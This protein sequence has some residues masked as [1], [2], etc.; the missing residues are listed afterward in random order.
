LLI[1]TYPIYLL[2]VIF[3]QA[4]KEN[5]KHDVG[6]NVL[7]P[8]QPIIVALDL[9]KGYT[10]NKLTG[11]SIK[12]LI[13]SLGDTIITGVPYSI[14]GSVELQLRKPEIIRSKM[15]SKE[16]IGSNVN[17]IR[18][19]PKII[20]AD[21]T[22]SFYTNSENQIRPIQNSSGIVVTGKSIPAIG[23]KIPL[24]QPQPIRVQPMRFKDNAIA[25]IQYLDI[26]QGLSYSYITAL[27]EDKNGYLWF[28]TDGYGLCKYDGVYLT[29]YT[30]KEGLLNNKVTC[31]NED[32]QGRIWIGNSSGISVLDGKS[33]IQFTEKDGIPGHTGF[34]K[35][36]RKGNLWFGSEIGG[37]TM[38]D[39]NNFITYSAKEGLP[40]NSISDFFEDSKG[41]KWI[42]T[43]SGMIK[44]DGK[45]FS[46]FN[47]HLNIL[48]A[49]YSIV[50]DRKGNIWFG[51]SYYGLIKYDGKVFTNYTENNGLPDHSIISMMIDRNDDV[52]ICTRYSGITKFDGTNFTAYQ[53]E[54]GLSENKTLDAIE[55]SQGNIWV[56]TFGGGINKINQNGFSEKVRLENVGNSR[57][58]PIIKDTM[59]QLWFGTEGGGLFA[60]DGTNII[61]Y[62]GK[63]PFQVK[64]FRSALVD[65][66]NNLWFGETDGNGLYKYDYKQFLYYMPPRSSANYAL[67]EDRNR[68]IWIGTSEEGAV[69]FNGTDF[70]YYNI[71][72]G[73]SSNRVL[74]ITEDKKNN[75]WFGT[76][77]AGV[78]KFDGQLFTV[79]SEKQGLFCKSVSSIIEDKNGNLWFGTLEAGLCKFDGNSFTYYTEKQGLALNA[80]WSV[81]EDFEGQIWAGTDKGLSLLIPQ[82]DT[83]TS[84]KSYVIYS[85][86]LGDGLNAT[87]FNLNGVCI[88]NSNRIWWATGKALITRDLSVPFKTFIPRSLALTHIEINGKLFDFRSL[89]D[90]IKD[91]INF[92]SIAPFHNYPEHLSIAYDQ[93]HI[94]FHFSAIDW[95]ASH[96]IKYSYRLIGSDHEWSFP[97]AEASADY[98][99]LGYGNYEFQVKAIGESQVWTDPVS[100]KFKI[101][102]AWWQT[103]LFKITAAII[104]VL[105]IMYVLWLIYLYRLRKQKILL[106]KKLAVEYERQRISAD[107]HDDIGSTLSSINIYAGLAKKQGDNQFYLDS[108]SQNIND[109]V[110]KLDDLVWSIK[111]GHD[112]LGNI[113][114]RLKAYAEPITRSKQ[115]AFSISMNDDWK[116]IKP[117][118]G[119]KHHLFMTAKELIN[120]A[121][122]H[123]DCKNIHIEFK[124]INNTLYVIVKDDGKGFNENAIRKDRNGLKN[125]AQR[126]TEMEG[127]L[128]IRSSLKDGTIVNIEIPI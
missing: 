38:Y 88:D 36:D 8:S 37:I 75:L 121:V 30:Q 14:Q 125:I 7:L 65:H 84:K 33:F 119:I 102:P 70:V 73:F 44:F 67:F 113:V 109:V 92:S 104:S 39:G 111:A 98:R 5:N 43:I 29:T 116:D 32:K 55:D 22:V 56:G 57:V 51:S 24:N 62:I 100:Y 9:D 11:D 105:V 91:K 81:K 17:P 112:T 97:S 27:Y 83:Q 96:K 74:T 128:D 13:N 58:R 18:N 87:D 86:G 45:H 94:N 68:T 63:D 19:I 80:I 110:G 49:V 76:E 71:K 12:P 72:N 59:G 85:F 127:K 126:V 115:I 10:I 107:L 31:I 60:Y 20:P 21:T 3:F 89:A 69:A 77:G 93:N 42:A 108:I 46:H 61:K 25:D 103:W 78:I 1:R 118:D 101:R 40:S 99:N 26:E 123:A 6:Q 82:N 41:N 124:K 114:E 52:W 53:L 15:I 66:N 28:G 79:F 120:N 48:R 23:T 2:L 54:Q 50:E 90:S 16:I 34:I 47:D 106:E 117:P 64:G 95:S 122:K 4:C 35:K